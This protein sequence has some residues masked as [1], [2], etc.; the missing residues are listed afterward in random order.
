MSSLEARAEVEGAGD[1]GDRSVV[2]QHADEGV[3]HAGAEA[4]TERVQDRHL[5]AR[6]AS[7]DAQRVEQAA[8]CAVD[9]EEEI[10]RGVERRGRGIDHPRPEFHALEDAIAGQAALRIVE[11][12][13]HAGQKDGGAEP[14]QRQVGQ[15]VR[16]IGPWPVGGEYSQRSGG[17]GYREEGRAERVRVSDPCLR[18]A[19]V[20]RS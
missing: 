13:D 8:Q 17:T 15:P 14:E 10:V 4:G 3:D 6:I 9:R 1:E 11:P 20:M 18:R 19:M 16:G 7:E 5:P 12:D 2:G